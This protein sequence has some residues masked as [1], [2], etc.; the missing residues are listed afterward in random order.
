[1]TVIQYLRGIL[2]TYIIFDI[3]ITVSIFAENIINYELKVIDNSYLWIIGYVILC[4]YILIYNTK[5]DA[6]E[7]TFLIL[8]IMSFIQLYTNTPQ[9]YL[10]IYMISN[11]S[12]SLII[13]GF[14]KI[15]KLSSGCSNICREEIQL[16]INNQ[17]AYQQV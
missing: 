11:L 1:M 2:L 6:F 5:D 9:N 14:I 4:T 10:L 3:I 8:T 13:V 16:N 12:I 17:D 7:E 15:L